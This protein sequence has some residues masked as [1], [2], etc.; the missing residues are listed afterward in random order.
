MTW[1]R[2][3]PFPQLIISHPQLLGSVSNKSCDSASFVWVYWNCAINPH[4]PRDYTSS[5]W[6]L[7][8]WESYLPAH[9]GDLCPT[10]R[11][12]LSV[13]HNLHVLSSVPQLRLL[14]TMTAYFL[15]KAKN[16][17]ALLFVLSALF[18]GQQT[19][20][21]KSHIVNILDL[22]CHMVSDAYSWY[23]FYNT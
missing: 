12:D 14:N 22:M 7:G 11:P 16:K 19:F 8:C 10:P 1:D 5:K 15:V 4:D 18:C 2:G 3:L 13:G 20:S 23:F 9:V 6:D 17:W 21:L